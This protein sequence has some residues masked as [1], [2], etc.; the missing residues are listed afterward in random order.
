[1][2]TTFSCLHV[3]APVEMSTKTRIRKRTSE[4]MTR[5]FS[6]PPTPT[7]AAAVVNVIIEELQFVYYALFQVDLN[8]NLTCD[9][10]TSIHWQC[11][12]KRLNIILLLW[13][14]CLIKII[15]WNRLLL[16]QKSGTKLE[17]GGNR[18]CWRYTY[19]VWSCSQAYEGCDMFGQCCS[20]AQMAQWNLW[21]FLNGV[22]V[23][24]N[25][26]FT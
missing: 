23:S 9:N 12:C 21:H 13:L 7:A 2:T 24:T 1:M 17:G 4:W 19:Y 15:N 6:A 11:M 3:F 26:K 5:Y 18:K 8:Y 14:G 20:Y 22:S 10:L 25:N 16:T